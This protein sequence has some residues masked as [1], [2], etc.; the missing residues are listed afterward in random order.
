ME[1][2]LFPVPKDVNLIKESLSP[3]AFLISFKLETDE[4]ML[5]KKAISA[6]SA[7]R[8]DIVVGNLLQKKYD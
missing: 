2:T 6:L 7:C 4:N 3:D 8:S 1:I 5:E